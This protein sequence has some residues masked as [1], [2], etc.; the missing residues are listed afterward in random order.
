MVNT[1]SCVFC[2]CLMTGCGFRIDGILFVGLLIFGDCVWMLDSIVVSL[3][4]V[5]GSNDNDGWVGSVGPV[6][7]WTWFWFYV[8]AII[9]VGPSSGCA[10][11][12]WLLMFIDGVFGMLLLVLLILVLNLKSAASNNVVIDNWIS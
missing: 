12:D 8:F 5:G 10:S 9:G 4:T 1:N 11:S 7:L 6:W 3:C 2:G